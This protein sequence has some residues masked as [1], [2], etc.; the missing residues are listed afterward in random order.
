MG[1][2]KRGRGNG[3]G[4]TRQ[5]RNIAVSYSQPGRKNRET[6]K[7]G[8]IR[9]KSERIVKDNRN[10]IDKQRGVIEGEGKQARLRTLFF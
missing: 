2:R 5:G 8:K 1:E 10:R 4:E 3:G 9:K 7:T 6:R